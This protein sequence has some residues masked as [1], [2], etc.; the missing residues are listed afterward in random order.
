[1][2]L[3][4]P[5]IGMGAYSLLQNHCTRLA[6]IGILLYAV[7]FQIIAL[8]S[9]FA[10]F[11]GCAT[12]TDAA[13]Y[14]FPSDAFCLD[15]APTLIDRLSVLGYPVVAAVGF[16]GGLACALLLATVWGCAQTRKERSY[17]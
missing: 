6:V 10:L 12:K 14:A 5:A 17:S 13:R 3:I 11:T 16:G 2:P 1:M 8:W 7:C 15:Q 9:Q 4:A